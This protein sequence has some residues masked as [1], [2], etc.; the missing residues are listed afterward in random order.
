MT[1]RSSDERDFFTQC[2]RVTYRDSF[3]VRTTVNLCP[4][5]T[6]TLS[7]PFAMRCGRIHVPLGFS[8]FVGEPNQESA[9]P[10]SHL[11]RDARISSILEATSDLIMKSGVRSVTM[12]A[13]ANESG[14]SRQWMY[15]FFPDVESIPHALFV[16]VQTNYFGTLEAAEPRTPDFQLSIADRVSSFLDMPVTF[17]M[18]TS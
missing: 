3:L 4:T 15:K 13:I 17:A 16:E 6:T 12:K 11:T 1:T 5:R 9:S 18:L 7:S 2:Q 8:Y 14:V 10:S